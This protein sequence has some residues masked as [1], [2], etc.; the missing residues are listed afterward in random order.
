M[1][2]SLSR[3]ELYF[4]HQL[5]HEQ[6]DDILGENLAAGLPG[7][8]AQHLHKLNTFLEISDLFFREGIPFIPQKG[9]VLSFR[10]YC[11]PLV[12]IYTDLDFLVDAERIPVAFRVLSHLGF[13]STSY[14]FPG[15]ECR[16][17]LLMQHVNELYL[18]NPDLE[19]GIELHWK[20]FNGFTAGR[21]GLTKVIQD[22]TITLKFGGR[23][24]TVLNP[25]L[26]LLY[27]VIHASLHGWNR[28]KWLVD[29]REL[30]RK[31]DIDGMKFASLVQQFRAQNPVATCNELLKEYFPG[32]K[33]LPSVSRAP[34]GMVRFA[35][36]QIRKPD[37]QKDMREFLG[38]FVNSWRAFPG[39][40]YKVDLLKS[41]LFATDLASVPRMPCSALAFYLVSPFWKMSRGFRG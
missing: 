1:I 33:L 31:F 30:L 11:D 3:D 20:L 32:T 4:R 16:Q 2:S 27:L 39:I 40:R 25:E 14:V 5:S 26:E 41:N 19:T 28:L 34:A 8:K 13:R 38:F 22:N 23:D 10:I 18:W 37:G 6:I 29:V 21:R 15:D 36:R 17:K 24:F 9:P 35:L 7:A 12:R